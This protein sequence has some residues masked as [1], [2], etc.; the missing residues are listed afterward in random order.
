MAW[1]RCGR[2]NFCGC[3]ICRIIFVRSVENL[4]EGGE[5]MER[6]RRVYSITEERL[7]SLSHGVAAVGGGVG[8]LLLVYRAFGGE[9]GGVIGA[10][11]YGATLFTV[12]LSSCLYHAAP[13]GTRVKARLERLD[14]CAIYLI[15]FGTYVPVCLTLL[16]GTA[17]Y[18]TL[19]AVGVCCAVGIILTCINLEKYKRVGFLLYL[20]AGWLI[21][22]ASVIM[23][24]HLGG[25]A[26][27]L[28]LLGGILYTGGVFFYKMQRKVYFHLVWHLLVMLGSLCHY[29]MIFLFLYG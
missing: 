25:G 12:F 17:G 27:S 13:S 26:A 24:P 8:W 21:F 10:G 15:I 2:L 22:P 4:G 20:V 7:H 29:L 16:R 23:R 14:H 6:A 11:V 18:L 1:M 19:G 3:F 5:N 9:L 28:L